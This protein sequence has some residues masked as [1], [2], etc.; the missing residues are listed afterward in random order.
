MAALRHELARVPHDPHPSPSPSPSPKSGTL[1]CFNP[2]PNPTPNPNPPG[3]LCYFNSLWNDNHTHGIPLHDVE[4]T[5]ALALAVT[6]A[7]H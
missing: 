3:T 4:A 5:L 2:T 6:L 7:L 1:C